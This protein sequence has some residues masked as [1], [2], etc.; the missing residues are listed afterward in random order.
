MQ[1]LNLVEP[2][3]YTDKLACDGPEF[4]AEFGAEHPVG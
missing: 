2:V 1:Q 4:D 3:R